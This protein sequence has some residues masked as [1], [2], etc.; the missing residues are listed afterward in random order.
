MQ[1]R[2]NYAAVSLELTPPPSFLHVRW[3]RSNALCSVPTH[4]HTLPTH[5]H[6]LCLN[7]SCGVFIYTNLIYS[8][9]KSFEPVFDSLDRFLTL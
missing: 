8:M 6:T 5:R 7:S 4:R 9:R 1:F 2:I 3:P